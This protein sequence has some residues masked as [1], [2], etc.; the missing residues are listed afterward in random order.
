MIVTQVYDTRY[1]DIWFMGSKYYDS[2][3]T[4][5]K[6]K[7]WCISSKADMCY[8]LAMFNMSNYNTISYVKSKGYDV[9]YASK[10]DPCEIVNVSTGNVCGGYALGIKDNE[11]VI[12]GSTVR[13]RNGIGITKSGRII[14]AQST[15]K[16]TEKNF[17]REVAIQVSQYYKDTVNVFLMED[18]GGSTQ[19]YSNISKLGIAPEGGRKVPTVTCVKRR[20]PQKVNRILK[21]GCAGEDVRYLQIVLGG[22]VTD[23]S[24][25]N[26]T[27]KRVK[28][29]QKELKALGIYDSAIDGICGPG[30]Q[31]ALGL[32]E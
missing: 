6:A 26:A 11:V 15:S 19:M 2:P 29:C 20:V 1:W 28:E 13:S 27:K 17:C 10:S 30:T 21:V 25:G 14:I 24:Y 3:K 23:G 5:L 8:N 7:E 31:K 12:K 9:G 4:A 32:K 16:V 22:L 18:G